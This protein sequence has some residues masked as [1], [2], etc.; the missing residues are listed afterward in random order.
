MW[1]THA[2]LLQYAF[3]ENV[4]DSFTDQRV[5][6]KAQNIRQL[7]ATN[8]NDVR[9]RNQAMLFC[10]LPSRAPTGLGSAVTEVQVIIV[11]CVFQR[12]NQ[13]LP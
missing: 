2:S 3:V 5:E 8:F 7:L 6:Q 1:I 13:I 9:R 11:Y 12:F 10:N 4:L